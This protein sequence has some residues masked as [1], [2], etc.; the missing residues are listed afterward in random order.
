MNHSVGTQNCACN[1]ERGFVAICRAR[2]WSQ[3]GDTLSVDTVL[4]PA[5]SLIVPMP[6]SK[7]GQLGIRMSFFLH[8][9]ILCGPFHKATGLRNILYFFPKSSQPLP[10]VTIKHK[11][12]TNKKSSHH[13]HHHHHNSETKVTFWDKQQS[14]TVQNRELYSISCSKVSWERIRKNNIYMYNKITL[15]TQNEHTQSC[16]STTI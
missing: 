5:L 6:Q 15:Y 16:K 9:Q 13:H 8:Q 14:S 7:N 11:N 2:H 3:A 10:V 1:L 12:S 4:S